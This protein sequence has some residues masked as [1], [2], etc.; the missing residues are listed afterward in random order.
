MQA[1][2]NTFSAIGGP[3]LLDR[4]QSVLIGIPVVL[5]VSLAWSGAATWDQYLVTLLSNI[6]I[7]GLVLL[8]SELARRTIFASI[9]ERP[10]NPFLVLAFGAGLGAVV[11]LLEWFLESSLADLAAL[12]SLG[13][14]VVFTVAG[15]I[16]VPAASLL[17]RAKKTL[18]SPSQNQS[19][20]SH[21]TY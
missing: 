14:L 3:W 19:R 16:L 1:L 2:K 6:L 12:P 4:L 11:Y 10:A 7:F 13:R 20:T 5:I 17:E 18:Q 15:A 8:T 9:R 21:R